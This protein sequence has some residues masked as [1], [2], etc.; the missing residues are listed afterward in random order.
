MSRNVVKQYQ[1]TSGFIKSTCWGP[2]NSPYV[3]LDI[4]VKSAA[5]GTLILD[6]QNFA[7]PAGG[8]SLEDT[9]FDNV[10]WLGGEATIT[11]N[12][13]TMNVIQAKLRVPT[14]RGENVAA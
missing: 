13:T 14:P 4:T 11:I 9:Y 12:G 3:G 1:A 2:D 10:R 6:G 7:V 8:I 5:G